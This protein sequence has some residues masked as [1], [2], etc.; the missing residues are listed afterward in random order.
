MHIT[1]KHLIDDKGRKLYNG[2]VIFDTSGKKFYLVKDTYHGILETI[3]PEPKVV[4]YKEIEGY[5]KRWLFFDNNP[6]Y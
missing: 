4:S 5:F 3:T 2:E 1:K 6:A